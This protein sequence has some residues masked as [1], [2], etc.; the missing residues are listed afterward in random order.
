MLPLLMQETD[1]WYSALWC[2]TFVSNST[3][4]A[5]LLTWTTT[6]LRELL[7]TNIPASTPNGNYYATM[8]LTSVSVCWITTLCITLY[9]G[10]VVYFWISTVS[11]NNLYIWSSMTTHNWAWPHST[12]SGLHRWWYWLKTRLSHDSKERIFFFLSRQFC[13][14]FQNF[15][16]LIVLEHATLLVKSEIVIL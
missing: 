9:N 16:T 4:E 7:D 10:C 13:M 2:V 11:I 8:I 6:I 12:W 1:R 3:T 5:S 14:Y 15:S